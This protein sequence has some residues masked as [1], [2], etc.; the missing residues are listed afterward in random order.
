LTG[1]AKCSQLAFSARLGHLKVFEAY[2]SHLDCQ[3]CFLGSE[4]LLQREKKL[5]RGMLLLGKK[6]T[7]PRLS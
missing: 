2:Q 1:F 5:Q 4:D 7:Y 6:N 3:A